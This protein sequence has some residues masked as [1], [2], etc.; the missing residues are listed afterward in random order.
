MCAIPGPTW[1]DPGTV[2]SMSTPVAT[3]TPTTLDGVGDSAVR[4]D[5]TLKVTAEFVYASDLWMDDMIWGVTLRSPNPYA[6]IRAIDIGP[7]LAT[8][9]VYAVLTADDV[10][11][12]NRVG[13]EHDDQPALAEDVVRYE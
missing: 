2:N 13:L 5:G 3:R 9:G 8:P 12:V 1:D 11:G 7:A 4:P 6:R 10:P